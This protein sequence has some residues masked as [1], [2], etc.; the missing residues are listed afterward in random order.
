LPTLSASSRGTAAS[1]I[2][3]LT[4]TTL[5]I[6]PNETEK[7]VDKIRRA[8]NRSFPKISGKPA[9]RS[10]WKLEYKFKKHA[11]PI[12]TGELRRPRSRAGSEK[13][14]TPME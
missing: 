7:R 5:S 1:W 4:L 8:L 12:R 9:D 14:A 6:A 11:T 3:E 2:I 13:L 10:V